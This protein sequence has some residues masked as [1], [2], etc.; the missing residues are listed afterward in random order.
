MPRHG[1]LL[2]QQTITKPEY[3]AIK[4]GDHTHPFGHYRC[5]A[6]A[7]PLS[8]LHTSTFLPPFP[9]R[10]FAFRAF[11]TA[12]AVFRLQGKPPKHDASFPAVSPWTALQSSS[13]TKALT[14][15]AVTSTTGLPAYLTHTSQRSAS[16]HVNGPDIALHA[17]TSVSDVF[18]AS[19]N[20]SRL[21]AID[22]RIEFALLRTASSLPVAPH[23]T[24]LRRSFLQL[25]GLGLPR[26][27]LPP[28]CV[29]AFTGALGCATRTTRRERPAGCY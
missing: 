20:P 5:F 11:P 19:P 22:R 18:Q 28:R 23:P 17:N 12:S 26:H 15:A 8:S 3:Q 13:T 4:S 24:S 29:C 27:G 25:R 1:V 21:A 16:N 7:L 2:A 14:P 10:G 6:H 9:R